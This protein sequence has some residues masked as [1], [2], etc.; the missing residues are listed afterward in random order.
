L[1]RAGREG[2]RDARLAAVARDWCELALRGAAAL[3]D[4]FSPAD[5]DEAGEF[6]ARYTRRGLSPAD[7]VAAE[8]AAG[9]AA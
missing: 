7:D 3:G 2:L 8:A 9:A 4:F 1:A 6:F 5:L